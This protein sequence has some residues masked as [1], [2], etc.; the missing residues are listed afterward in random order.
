MSGDLTAVRSYAE[1]NV[2]QADAAAL[3][4]AVEAIANSST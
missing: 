1:A 2:D 4:S 3:V